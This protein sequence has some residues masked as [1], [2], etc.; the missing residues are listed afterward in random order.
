MLRSNL[1]VEINSVKL[2]TRISNDY[3]RLKLFKCILS[4][5]NRKKKSSTANFKSKVSR[6]TF[7]WQNIVS[8]NVLSNKR[9]I[10]LY[11]KLK[12]KLSKYHS[13]SFLQIPQNGITDDGLR[14]EN[15][16][17]TRNSCIAV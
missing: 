10:S 15:V 5:T 14:N 4:N 6:S 11:L 12:K 3:K 8:C 13:I 2:K 17:T 16:P 1:R 7:N 9:L